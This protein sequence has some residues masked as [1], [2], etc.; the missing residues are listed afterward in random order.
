MFNVV[1]LKWITCNVLFDIITV[2][3]LCH[4]DVL[5]TVN[6]R[7]MDYTFFTNLC[8]FLNRRNHIEEDQLVIDFSGVL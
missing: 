8:L 5:A 2:L 1:K 6:S 3:G 7:F 4:I